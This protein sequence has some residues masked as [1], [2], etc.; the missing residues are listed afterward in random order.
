MELSDALQPCQLLLLSSYGVYA[1][2]RDSLG[3]SPSDRV[4]AINDLLIDRITTQAL[5]ATLYAIWLPIAIRHNPQLLQAAL[6][7]KTSAC[8]RGTAIKAISRL[9]HGPK[10]KTEGWDTLGGVDGLASIFEAASVSE[11]RA[12]AKAISR[13]R[14]SQDDGRR[15]DCV[16]ALLQRLS[17][18][19]ARPLFVALSPLY[20]LCSG[21]FVRDVVSNLPD[22]LAVKP[23]LKRVAP[24][25]PDLLRQ[26]AVGRVPAPWHV[27][28]SILETCQTA[29]VGSAT[30]YSSVRESVPAGL[31]PGMAFVLDLCHVLAEDSALRRDFHELD[32]YIRHVLRGAARHHIPFDRI[33]PFF[34]SIVQYPSCIFLR[35]SLESA[36]ARELLRC[37][38]LVT[39]GKSS[40]DISF[41]MKGIAH[42]DHPSHPRPEHRLG[43]ESALTDLLRRHQDRRLLSKRRDS[44]FSATQDLLLD[45]SRPARRR[46]LEYLVGLSDGLCYDPIYEKTPFTFDPQANPPRPRERQLVPVWHYDVLRMLP[47]ADAQVIFER[48][49]VIHGCKGFVPTANGLD[50][51]QQCRLKAQWEA[52]G[53]GVFLSLK[54]HAERQRDAT[55]RSS[56]SRAA[57]QVAF[58]TYDLDLCREAVSW[59]RRFIR[60][61]VVFPDIMSKAILRGDNAYLSCVDMPS[62][63]LP[64]DM[65]TL[66]AT[67]KSAHEVLSALLETILLA[68]CE[69]VDHR[70]FTKDISSFLRGLVAARI[71]GMSRYRRAG[72]GSEADIVDALLMPLVSILIAWERTSDS[73]EGFSTGDEE[74]PSTD[75]EDEAA[76]NQENNG[77][78]YSEKEGWT[79]DSGFLHY[80]ELPTECPPAVLRFFDEYARRRNDLHRAQRIKIF[81]DVADMDE[82]WP[83]GLQFQCLLPSRPWFAFALE[84]SDIA[85]YMAGRI[86]GVLEASPSGVFVPQ[87]DH[88]EIVDDDHVDSFPVALCAL[89]DMHHTKRAKTDAVR[90]LWDTYQSRKDA[91]GKYFPVLRDFLV[92]LLEEELLFEAAS[93]VRPPRLAQATSYLPSTNPTALQ[94]WDPASSVHEEARAAVDEL[95]NL[96]ERRLATNLL[97]YQLQGEL[98]SENHIS[99]YEAPFAHLKNRHWAWPKLRFERAL[100]G[101]HI[102]RKMSFSARE[103]TI[104]SALLY[105]EL[106]MHDLHAEET[107]TDAQSRES[108]PLAAPFPDADTVRYPAIYLKEDFVE[109]AWD[110]IGKAMERCIDVLR[111]SMQAVPTKMVSTLMDKVLDALEV[112]E[113]PHGVFKV[114]LKT[115]FALIQAL[116]LSDSPGLAVGPVLRVIGSFPS[117]SAYHRRMKLLSLCRRLPPDSVGT[118]LDSFSAFVCKKLVEQQRRDPGKQEA[119]RV[120]PKTNAP[121]YVKIT[122]VK[123]LAQLLAQADFLPLDTTVR[124]LGDTFH[125]T[126]H[127]DIRTEIVKAALNLF[128]RVHGSAAGLDRL[129][130]F[131]KSIAHEIAQEPSEMDSAG[132]IST[133]TTALP[134]VSSVKERPELQIL[135]EAQAKLPATLHAKYVQEILLPFVETSENVHNVW[136]GAFLAPL[137]LSRAKLGIPSFGPFDPYL[138]D[139]I[140]FKWSTYL[141][142]RYLLDEHNKWA[143]THAHHWQ[144]YATIGNTLATTNPEYR[145][146]NAGQHWEEFVTR[147]HETDP[148]STLFPLLR[149]DALLAPHVADG[150]TRKT[151]VFEFACRTLQ[152]ARD[153]AQY[154]PKTGKMRVTLDPLISALKQL[155][156]FRITKEDIGAESR[157]ARYIVTDEALRSVVD[158]VKSLRRMTDHKPLVLPT[159]FELDVLVL[160]SP[161]YIPDAER[162]DRLT[163]FVEAVVGVVS[164]CVGSLALVLEFAA[165]ESVVDEVIAEDIVRVVELLNASRAQPQLG[166]LERGLIVK[167]AQRLLN[168]LSDDEVLL[169]QELRPLVD[170]WRKD[171]D[172][173]VS[174]IGWG[175]CVD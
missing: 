38:S 70:S 26:M 162:E 81:P 15:S 54:K 147:L 163:Q 165:L 3:E 112:L 150:I 153:P 142:A 47:A 45:V 85:P 101:S 4:D 111:A 144:A 75:K 88:D 133:W 109:V 119:P 36:V 169:C 84:H 32:V 62:S 126:H 154:F 69:P 23:L 72:I 134:N 104:V 107:P 2:F 14:F 151:V 12:L 125:S 20:A 42:P 140:L 18:G 146:T 77:I 114:V 27:R 118:F 113:R 120:T 56:A 168:R 34:T 44:S 97:Y 121:D 50:H 96:K 64:E 52:E 76:T 123:M 172:E 33:I 116:V 106:V 73:P 17:Q 108:S 129:F 16:E 173:S 61:P 148:I 135:I 30:P 37:W 39:A 59:T 53:T 67:V 9:F 158:Y 66:R 65:A 110:D 78:I 160:P 170:G 41:F 166:S 24:L 98:D 43:L 103:A 49:L 46:F 139:T 57:L 137:G 21:P 87:P 94:A 93:L 51:S 152:L 71:R 156:A 29:L 117:E 141:P 83:Q 157:R 143:L 105:L 35:S 149:E 102:V 63:R 6:Q 175:V 100:A 90:A 99:S 127:I 130:A 89:L 82:G 1:R 55:E 131:I 68:L 115:T 138:I 92:D 145:Q 161:V 31:M 155:R 95:S 86:R 40:P 124:I 159:P 167:L 122:T 174:R 8:I 91:Y 80:L 58:D 128:D 11:V 28:L 132:D 74:E 164:S 19:S 22:T 13:C 25:H 79:D 7:N 171:E 60:D 48:M 136:M 10:W 5:P